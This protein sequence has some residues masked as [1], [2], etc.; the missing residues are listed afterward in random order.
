MTHGIQQSIEVNP[1]ATSESTEYIRVVPVPTVTPKS[2]GP[3]NVHMNAQ[4]SNEGQGYHQSRIGIGN[5]HMSCQDVHDGRAASATNGSPESI[6]VFLSSM[7]RVGGF[8]YRN[9]TYEDQ[10]GHKRVRNYKFS[11]RFSPLY[12]RTVQYEENADL[13][14]YYLQS[15]AGTVYWRP[16]TQ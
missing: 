12:K 2:N 16:R 8:G 14:N 3:V 7:I 1:F 10:S 13:S 11:H 5:E 6:D 4:T 9:E 15:S